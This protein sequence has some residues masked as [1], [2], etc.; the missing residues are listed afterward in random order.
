M[1][2]LLKTMGMILCALIILAVLY[3]FIDVV[4]PDG[5]EVRCM[6]NGYSKYIAALKKG[7]CLHFK[8][9]VIDGIGLVD[10]GGNTVTALGIGE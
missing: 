2:D 10:F 7:Y 8:D 4:I 3:M 1:D 6:E 9:G 5:S